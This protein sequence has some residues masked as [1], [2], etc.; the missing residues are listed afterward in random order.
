M[1]ACNCPICGIDGTAQSNPVRNP[2]STSIKTD[3]KQHFSMMITE[4]RTS[5]E[6]SWSVMFKVH[7]IYFYLTGFVNVPILFK[8]PSALR[9]M[10]SG[11][12]NVPILFKSPSV[13]RYMSSGFLNIPILFKLPSVLRYMKL[14]AS[15]SNWSPEKSHWDGLLSSPPVFACQ[16]L[17]QQC[18]TFCNPSS[19]DG[20]K[21]YW[22]LQVH[23]NLYIK[24]MDVLQSTR[25][26]TDAGTSYRV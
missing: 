24:G 18:S 10:S 7:N 2:V 25:T 15:A 9:Y 1:L 16:F 23:R 21:A 4:T 22:G 11:F 5:L 17:V 13:L 8:L 6:R 20:Q 26:I 19:E 3:R 12:L 14:S